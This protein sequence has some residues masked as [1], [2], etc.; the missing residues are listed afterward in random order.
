MKSTQKM[1]KDILKIGKIAINLVITK[2]IKEK[3]QALAVQDRR[4]MTLEL[5]FLIDEEWKKRQAD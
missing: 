2:E 3:L 1:D 4:T 5:E